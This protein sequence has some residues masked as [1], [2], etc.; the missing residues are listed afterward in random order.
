MLVFLAKHFLML[1]LVCLKYM[2][3]CFITFGQVKIQGVVINT[4]H[5]GDKENKHNFPEIP[6]WLHLSIR[7]DACKHRLLWGVYRLKIG[8]Y[9]TTNNS[10]I[11]VSVLIVI[12][13]KYISQ[14]KTYQAG[15]T[16]V[17]FFNEAVRSNLAS[18]LDYGLQSLP[19]RRRKFC[20]ISETFL[21]IKWS[22]DQIS[23]PSVP[24]L[25]QYLWVQL[26]HWVFSAGLFS[27]INPGWSWWR[28]D[29]F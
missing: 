6:T 24:C 2:H 26:T 22:V 14:I 1:C 21:V 18:P 7:W 12:G 16:Q 5:Q 9:S 8:I 19:C 27:L 25:S 13:T 17:T 28:T 23:A 3:F 11:D 20:S 15:L 4:W 29:H 10:W